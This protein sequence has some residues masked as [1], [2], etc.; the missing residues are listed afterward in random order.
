M[1]KINKIMAALMASVALLMMTGETNCYAYGLASANK[2]VAGVYLECTLVYDES[3]VNAVASF[4]E[5]SGTVMATAIGYFW[6]ENYNEVRMSKYNSSPLPGGV[7]ATVNC[8]DGYSFFAAEGEY[9]VDSSR[10]KGG[11]KSLCVF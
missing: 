7:S 8:M 3:Y 6:N 1:K 4:S 5:G 11:D 2:N 10:G 9:E